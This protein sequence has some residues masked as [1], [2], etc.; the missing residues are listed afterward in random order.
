MA[1]RPWLAGGDREAAMRVPHAAIVAI[2]AALASSADP[3]LA[4]GGSH[5]HLSAAQAATK[6]YNAGVS[7]VDKA[8]E[9][10]T[11]AAGAGAPDKHTRALEQ[12]R[13]AYGAA[14]EEFQRAV[15]AKPD[16][17]QGW[18]YIGYTQRHLGDYSAALAAYARALEINP[19]YEEA[20]EYRAEAY[21]GLNRIED[22]KGAY[23]ELFRTSRPLADQ[24]MQS[25]HAWIAERQRDPSGIDAEVLRAFAQW[26][27][28][29]AAIAQQTASLA[30]DRAARPTTDWK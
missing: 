19:A 28:E 8:H 23:M 10:E 14:L 30:T 9:R 21:L 11:A 7:D 18:N 13:R 26:V 15:Q 4:A 5:L 27:E 24:L 20:I 17:Y 1:L 22:A 3:A 12:A 6:A 16:L 25:M 29:R 2:F